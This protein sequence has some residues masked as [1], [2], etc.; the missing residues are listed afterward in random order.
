[1]EA[2]MVVRQ[3]EAG[4][5]VEVEEEGVLA[6]EGSGI[7]GEVRVAKGHSMSLIIGMKKAR[8]KTRNSLLD[9]VCVA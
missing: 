6:G 1:M 5:A 2:G 9:E 8:E 4:A 3:A 7:N